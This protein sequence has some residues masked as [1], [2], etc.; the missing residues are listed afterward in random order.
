MCLAMAKPIDTMT[1][2]IANAAPIMVIVCDVPSAMVFVAVAT[3]PGIA[4]PADMDINKI[5]NAIANHIIVGILLLLEI[6]N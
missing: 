4:L 2:R 6:F 1:M 3:A 5:A